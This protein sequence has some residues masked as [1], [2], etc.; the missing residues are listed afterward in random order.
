[1]RGISL[2]GILGG[3]TVTVELPESALKALDAATPAEGLAKL[4][5]AAAVKLFEM[6]QIS[7]GAAADLAGIHR[8]EFLSRLKDFGV[9]ALQ[10]SAEDLRHD[11][12]V[13]GSRRGA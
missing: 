7:S 1:M 8:I 10:G 12:A 5:M 2:R 13:L 9:A 4:R 6:G 3:M 11:I